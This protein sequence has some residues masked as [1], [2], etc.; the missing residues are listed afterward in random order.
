MTSYF[1]L[2]LNDFYVEFGSFSQNT[3][4]RKK[5]KTKEI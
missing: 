2:G 3:N 5:I 4:E 1:L